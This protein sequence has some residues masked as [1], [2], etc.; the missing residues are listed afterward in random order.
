MKSDRVYI[1]KYPLRF[2]RR[3][4]E[5]FLEKSEDFNEGY[6]T[7]TPQ[8]YRR[9]PKDV[10]RRMEQ[11]EKKRDELHEESKKLLMEGF[12]RGTPVE[13]AITELFDKELHNKASKLRAERH[14]YF[15]ERRKG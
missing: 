10:L 11:L 12:A 6:D 7:D 15:M 4:K 1:C 5:Y 3:D 13:T 9:I 2:P 14:Q 8:Y